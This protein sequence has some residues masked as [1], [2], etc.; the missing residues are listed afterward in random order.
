M[1][2]C[3]LQMSCLFLHW[4]FQ[5][6]SS[7]LLNHSKNFSHLCIFWFSVRHTA[8]RCD[9]EAV[10]DSL[11]MAAQNPTTSCS[12]VSKH[13]HCSLFGAFRSTGE[14]LSIKWDENVNKNLP[15]FHKFISAYLTT[16][17][18]SP[19]ADFFCL[20]VL[21]FRVKSTN[22]VKLVCARK[23]KIHWMLILADPCGCLCTMSYF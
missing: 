2:H 5:S 1:L 8:Y 23:K 18:Q 15:V 16:V 7:V 9:T 19:H 3:C 21:E 6:V 20:N 10:N 12:W 17:G 14:S 13:N 11:T 4:D 22:C